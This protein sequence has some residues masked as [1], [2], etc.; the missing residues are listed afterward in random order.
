MGSFCRVNHCDPFSA[1]SKSV[2]NATEAVPLSFIVMI[3]NRAVAAAIENPQL[4]HWW[5]RFKVCK[6]SLL[7]RRLHLKVSHHA[8]PKVKFWI[9]KVPDLNFQNS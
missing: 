5:L 6:A 4:S 1:V 2:A 7:I 3:V 8:D 9:K